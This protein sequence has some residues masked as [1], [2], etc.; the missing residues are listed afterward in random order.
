MLCATSF[1][2]FLFLRCGLRSG[3]ET[4]P[5]L[6][7]CLPTLELIAALCSSLYDGCRCSAGVELPEA[8]SRSA[9]TAPLL[10]WRGKAG[11]RGSIARKKSVNKVPA[12]WKRENFCRQKSRTQFFLKVSEDSLVWTQVLWRVF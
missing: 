12:M 5:S 8:L 3:G 1:L 11:K 4:V 2:L 9:S 6:S 10:R 7:T